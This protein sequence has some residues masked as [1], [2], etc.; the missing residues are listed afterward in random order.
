MKKR[1][2]HRFFPV[3]F[4]NYSRAPILQGIYKRVDLKHQCGGLSLIKFRSS[5]QRCSARKGVLSSVIKFPVKHLCQ[6]LVFNKVAGLSPATLLKKR[7]WHRC[8]PV[9]FVKFLRTPFLHNASGQ[10]L[11]KVTSLAHLTVLERDSSTGISPWILWNFLESFFCRTPP[12]NHFSHDI[13]FFFLF[14]DQRGL[15]PKINLFGGAMVNEKEF[16][17]PFNVV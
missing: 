16:R 1:L 17:S 14:A 2:Q 13:V 9:N 7:L 10:L 11:L 4:V 15:Q 12:S 5:H 6:S 3:N 8:F